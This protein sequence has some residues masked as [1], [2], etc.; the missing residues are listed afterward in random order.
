[1]LDLTA[2]VVR[3]Q[4]CNGLTFLLHFFSQSKLDLRF[5]SR[6]TLTLSR[7]WRR[8][9]HFLKNMIGLFDCVRTS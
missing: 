9:I 5:G 6:N 8:Y 4:F 3:S 1:M 7:P 2:F